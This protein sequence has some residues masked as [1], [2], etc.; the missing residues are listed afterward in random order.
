MKVKVRAFATLRDLIGDQ[1]VLELPEGST[2][3]SLL[4][5]LVRQLGKGLEEAILDERGKPAK[6]VKIMVNGRDIDFLSGLDTVLRDGDEVSLF[7]PVG[8]G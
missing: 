2:V 8:G 3:G 7:P 4:D 6:F 1:L 5:E